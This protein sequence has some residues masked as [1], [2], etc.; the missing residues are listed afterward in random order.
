MRKPK[1]IVTAKSPPRCK[2]WSLFVTPSGTTF[3]ISD[4]PLK[5]NQAG[6]GCIL[7]GMIRRLC[8]NLSHRAGLAVLLLVAVLL[9]VVILLLAQYRSL[10]GLESK[11]RA[12]AQE[13]LRQ[14]LQSFSRRVAEKIEAQAAE[15]LGGVDPS[16][17]EQERLDRI[18]DR[19]SAIRQSHSETDLAFVVIHCS[20]RKRNFAIFA[21]PDGVRRIDHDHL[22]RSP[23]AQ[24]VI[25]LYKN[26]ALLRAATGV[27]HE[28]LFE[29]SHCSI[30]PGEKIEPSSVFVFT[31][32][33]KAGGQ[34]EIG[35]AGM[36]LK[37]SYIRERLLPQATSELL[38]GA[39]DDSAPVISV[40]DENDREVYSNV[41]GLTRR[42]IRLPLSPVLRQ[43][44]MA[45]GYRNTTIEELARGQFRQNLFLIGAATA[46]LL[47][48]LILATRA[49]TREM[50][51]VEA[52][53][54]FVS[55]VSHELKTPLSLIRLFAETLELGRVRNSE[56]AQ[57]YYRIINRESRRLTR[58][59]N[60][61]LDFSRIEARRRQYQFSE[62]DVADVVSETLQ[63]HEYQM[64][65]AG[66]QVRTDIQPELPPAL[67]DREALA[68][69]VLNL[70]DN[71]VRYSDQTK[72]IEVGVRPRGGDIA[73]D[74]AD[75]G[76]GIPRSE[77]QR[78]FEKFYR[79]STGAVHDTKGSGLGLAIVKHIVEAHRGRVTVES[80]PGKGSRFTILL[81]IIR[82]EVTE[83]TPEPLNPGD[84]ASR[85]GYSVA[86]N[87]HH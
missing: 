16:D 65:N 45:I 51:L 40:L 33:N 60:N 58:L 71:A 29:Q 72:R 47:T 68:Q 70:L 53:T 37:A 78:V 76:I 56:E 14:T 49:T 28:A 15:T 44:K 48:G 21:S 7:G 59:I 20:C 12:A 83:A 26:A 85:G 32:I 80:A 81:P 9:P 22:R 43:W 23:E 25:E 17:V 6:R 31:A 57:E 50:K 39:G 18:A 11:T 54:T 62:A 82:S 87:P 4:P 1:R 38:R 24:A 64:L 67:I 69:A 79:V 42:E 13:N 77:H 5:L 61:I 66:F 41:G 34:G 55:N 52:K 46:L 74:V 10:A 75:H 27:S 35:F 30:F 36:T 63:I 84:A 73:I 8:F 19:L 2:K 3:Y 86:E